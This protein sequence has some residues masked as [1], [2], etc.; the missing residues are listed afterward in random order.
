MSDGRKTVI[1]SAVR[2]PIAAM[3]GAMCEI[4]A[5]KL[6]AAAIA[7]AV[8]R[9]GIPADAID[10][11]I[12]GNVLIGGEGQA[13]ARQAA[14]HA[15]LP[16][17]VECATIGKVCGSGAK[18]I[19]LADQA[20]RCGD[21]DVIVAGGMESMS[22][23]AFALLGARRGYRMGNG[24]LID[25]MIYDGLWDPYGNK[26]MGNFGDLCAKEKG[27]TRKDQDDFSIESFKRAQAA[28]N[29]GAFKDEI[30]PVALPSKKGEP[31]MFAE[32]EGPKK[33]NF[34]K[35]PTL[36]PAFSPD[37]T[38]TAA[39]ASSINDG[40]A[41][42]VLMGEDKANEMGCKPLA[43]ILSQASY[44]EPPEWFT[45]APVGSINK[46]LKKAGLNAAD[47]DLWEIN[48][49][50]SVVTLYAM[51]ELSLDHAK[52]NVNGGAVALGHPIGATGARLMVTL[53]NALKNRDKK[54]GAISMCIGGG[55][56]MTIIVERL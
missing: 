38:V 24:N 7:E 36:K 21:A 55:E 35:M 51:R 22:N 42:V 40:A 39:N 50:F 12:M 52:V 30:V 54:L 41:A 26:H 10:E 44:A 2:T 6:G 29:N 11:C 16:T 17:K 32:D 27:F 3:N 34:E 37:G 46:A 18:A 19:G 43:R 31:V 8:K 4:P 25:L 53:L 15:K 45:I 56:A 48:E 28:Q 5:P 1:V 23:A 33:A 20:I 47:I 13:P 14:I 9:S 49:A